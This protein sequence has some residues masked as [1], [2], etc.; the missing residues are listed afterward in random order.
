MSIPM[1]RYFFDVIDAAGVHRDQEGQLFPTAQAADDEALI[2]LLDIAREDMPKR[3]GGS[4]R[5]DVRND[6]DNSIARKFLEVHQ[7]VIEG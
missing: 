7:D 6:Q 4:L 2:A 1:P 5:I 3:R